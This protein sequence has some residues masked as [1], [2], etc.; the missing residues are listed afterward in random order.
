MSLDESAPQIGRRE[1]L[2]QAWQAQGDFME[3]VR[4]T[5]DAYFASM[6]SLEAAALAVRSTV[7]EFQAVLNLSLLEDDDLNRIASARP[8]KTTWLSL[9]QASSTS[10]TAALEALE[11]R[12]SDESPF[13]VVRQALSEIEGPTV[14]EKVAALSG[15]TVEQMAAKAV[16]YKLLATKQQQAIANFA[17]L[18]RRGTPLTPAQVAYLGNLLEQLVAGGAVRPDSPDNDQDHCDAVLAALRE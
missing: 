11:R 3:W 7:A 14:Q 8:P 9:A 1:R 4:G 5:A 15:K 12:G 18:K 13:Y 2:V 10:L 6:Y 17:A 16:Q